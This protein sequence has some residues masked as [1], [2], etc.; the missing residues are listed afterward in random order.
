MEEESNDDDCSVVDDEEYE[1]CYCLDEDAAV[2]RVAA[3]VPFSHVVYLDF[4]RFED[5]LCGSLRDDDS[6]RRQLRVDVPRSVVR[7]DDVRAASPDPIP[8]RVARFC[9]Q[10][11]MGLPLEI[12]HR[13]LGDVSVVCECRPCVP[14]TVAVWTARRA[15]PCVHVSKTLAL[16]P[17]PRSLNRGLEDAPS[18][19]VHVSVVADPAR[20]CAQIA[21]DFE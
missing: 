14:M 6:V 1:F 9:T 17:L 13:S 15:S 2:T 10:A 3:Y 21:F 12:L 20:D 4:G 11:V 18:R 7:V 19:R 5:D 16:H 8:S